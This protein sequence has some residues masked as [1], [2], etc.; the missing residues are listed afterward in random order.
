MINT[1]DQ[2]KESYY[3]ITGKNVKIKNPYYR[4]NKRV[5]VSFEGFKLI[6]NSNTHRSRNCHIVNTN[7]LDIVNMSDTDIAFQGDVAKSS[8]GDTQQRI[9]DSLISKD[10]LRVIYFEFFNHIDD[11]INI[12]KREYNIFINRCFN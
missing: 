1:L 12:V 10:E 6:M 3:I 8:R 5:V 9:D 11:P 2:A 4:V 7:L